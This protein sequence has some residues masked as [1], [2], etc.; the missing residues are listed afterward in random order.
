M[1][2]GGKLQL[3]YSELTISISDD[4]RILAQS[5]G[6]NDFYIV[7]NGVTT[8]PVK[9]GD[10]R[11]AGFKNI[12][13][14]DPGKETDLWANNE[15]ISKSG[16]KYLIKFGG[17]SYGPYAQIKDFTVTR[18]KDKFAAMAVENMPVS[19]A[20]GKKMDE[21]IKNAKSEQERRD[22]ATKYSQEMMRKMQQAG[23]PMSTMP[24]LVTNV[25]GTNYDPLK[26]GGG[27]LNRN[28]KYDE[29]VVVAFDK[30]IDLQGKVI[31]TLKQEAIGVPDIY[32]NTTN[33]KYAFYKYGTLTFNDNTTMSDLFNLHLIKVNGQ[34]YLA[35]MYYSPKKNAIMQCKIL[36]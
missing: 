25:A 3:D 5:R 8:G 30:L 21:A 18:S 19:E 14:S 28:I 15:Y 36:F 6:S 12:E 7:Q 34:V 27:T 33:T 16:E 23:G 10:P 9:S 20:E 32:V 29:I 1:D 24:K 22:L 31:L 13:N 4:D 11:L 35:Y 17:N 26:S 2:M